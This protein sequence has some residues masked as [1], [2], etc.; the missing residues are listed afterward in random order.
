M[1]LVQSKFQKRKKKLI[2]DC[3]TLNQSI[4]FLKTLEKNV[5]YQVERLEHQK[6]LVGSNINNMNILLNKAKEKYTENKNQIECAIC[7][8]NKVEYVTIPCGHLYCGKCIN[9]IEECF[10]CR[11]RITQIQKMYFL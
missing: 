2:N 8:E 3:D 5:N 6:K 7:M 4:F 10:Y 9:N 1:G 11:K